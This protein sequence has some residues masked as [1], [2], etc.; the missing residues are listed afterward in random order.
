[1]KAFLI[2]LGITYV[3][4]MTL[5]HI[6]NIQKIKSENRMLKLLNDKANLEIKRLRNNN[7]QLKESNHFLRWQTDTG[8]FG[9][10]DKEVV[11][12]V[13]K[14]MIYSHPDKG[15]CSTS[16]DFIKYKKLYERIRGGN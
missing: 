12:A 5:R 11:E 9:S 10:S 13:K 8:Y 6:T 3:T 15:I 14:L 16:D 7:E 2:G 4:C 1:M